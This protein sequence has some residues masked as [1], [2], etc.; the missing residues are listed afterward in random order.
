[1]QIKNSELLLTISYINIL[2]EFTQYVRIICNLNPMKLFNFSNKIIQYSFYLLFFLVPLAFTSDTSELFEFNK[3]WV[4]FILTLTIALAWFTKMVI[5]KKFTIQRTPLDIPIALFLISEI[6]STILSMDF[7]VSLWGYYS[8]FNGGLFS[9]LSY[10]FLYYAFVSNLNDEKE[11]KANF[12]LKNIYIFLAGIVVFFLGTLI[13][14]GIKTTEAAG[15]PYQMFATLTTAVVA[16]SVFMYGAPK[17]ML[18][19]SFY[20]IFSSA[21]LVVLWGLPS[22]FGYDPTCLLFRGTFDVSCWTNDFQPK[23]R[24]FSTMGQPDWMGAYIA[25][26]LP[27]V[28]AFTVNFAKGKVFFEKK[29]SSLLN[30]NTFYLVSAAVVFVFFYLSLLYTGS[31]SSILAVWAI[32]LILAFLYFWFFLKK[33]LLEKKFHL[34]FKL[35]ISLIFLTALVTFFAG[36]PFN[37]LN[38]LTFSGITT[39]LQQ[40]SHPVATV[41]NK[42]TV[43][44]PS[45]TQVANTRPPIAKVSSGGTDSSVLRLLVWTGGIQI[46]KNN[47]IFGTGLETYAFAYY[48]YRPVAHNLTSEWKYLYN[49]A[50][51]EYINY[52][53]TTGTV[54][55]VTYLSMIGGFLFITYKY[56]F[57]KRKNLNKNDF[58]IISLTAGYATILITNFFGFSVVMINILFYLTPAFVFMYAGLLN[59]E[60]QFGFSLSKKDLY[61]IGAVQKI[62]IIVAAGTFIYLIYTLAN[63]WQADRDYYFGVNYDKAQDYQKAYVFLKS[64]ISQRPDEP[65]FR[66]EFSY[67]NAVLGASIASQIARLPKDQQQQST[68]IAKQLIDSAI[69]YSNQ[70]T[71]ENPNNIVFWKTRTRVFY[72]LGQIDPSYLSQALVAIKKSQELAPTDPDISYNLGVLQG[73]TGDYKAAV[74]T[75]ENTIKLKYDY[76]A[77]NAYYALAIFYHQLAIDSKG[78]IINKDYNDK[79]IAALKED[80]RI[81][82]TNPQIEGALKAWSK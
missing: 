70:V 29:F 32:F 7:H 18:R 16:F 3:L 81:F 44:T 51:N 12:G 50:H 9:I 39:A 56:L 74:K 55:I 71:T 36:Q 62:T 40:K 31:R 54:G 25:V 1:M 82:G 57:K 76:P 24:I 27:V 58:I 10:I 78:N 5:R 23:T 52:L 2:L 53:A 63:F 38:K 80:V 45:L 19:K 73:Q 47:P 20:A 75:L 48:K 37:Q 66:D 22:H 43:S 77:G 17:G 35:F 79:A 8:R 34:D 14:S 49:K 46:W 28:L 30:L 64:A 72:T 13:S 41:N 68:Q 67:N 33:E 69:S 61:V 4:T 42:K 26:L 21:L 6:I 65:V 59:P 60:K 15:I 11:E